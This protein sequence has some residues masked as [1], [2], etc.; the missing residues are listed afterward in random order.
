MRSW[1]ITETD[2]GR[3]RTAADGEVGAQVAAIHD[4]DLGICVR[5]GQGRDRTADLPL[6]RRTLVPTELPGLVAN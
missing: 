1:R 2:H 5:G 6:F 4:P 3:A